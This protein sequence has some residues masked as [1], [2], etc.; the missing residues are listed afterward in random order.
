MLVFGVKSWMFPKSHM[1]VSKNETDSTLSMLEGNPTQKWGAFNSSQTV[2]QFQRLLQTIH[3][4]KTHKPYKQTEALQPDFFSA[5]IGA[6]EI[7]SDPQEGSTP[8]IDLT[9][10]DSQGNKKPPALP[11]KTCRFTTGVEDFVWLSKQEGELMK[12]LTLSIS[13]HGFFL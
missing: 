2:K 7:L 5:Q 12:L 6:S 4:R 9:P 8:I 11:V 13:V 10:A 1:N 3:E